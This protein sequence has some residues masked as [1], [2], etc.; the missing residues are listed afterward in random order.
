MALPRFLYS[1]TESSPS[2]FLPQ[3]EQELEGTLRSADSPPATRSGGTGV[4]PE[5]ELE[6]E[7][8]FT[9][10]NTTTKKAI[11]NGVSHSGG[12]ERGLR[13]S[14]GKL[15]SSVNTDGKVR[16]VGSRMILHLATSLQIFVS[17]F[18]STTGEW[19]L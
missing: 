10:P 17:W 12:I 6:L 5:E 4:D 3:K 1:V 7:P 19:E 18:P 11:S 2:P 8:R 15:T 14:S 16:G 13:S 9:S